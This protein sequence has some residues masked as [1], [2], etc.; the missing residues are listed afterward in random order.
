[1]QTHNSI[2]PDVKLYGYSELI[3]PGL[4]F[5]LNEVFPRFQTWN[6]INEEEQVTVGA[7]CMKIFHEFLMV[8]DLKEN[9]ENFYPNLFRKL[10]LHSVLYTPTGTALL[11]IV[12]TGTSLSF[13]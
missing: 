4:V 10:I 1:M 6:Y 2:Q 12:A 8:E 9:R 7:I 3:L 13:S 11:K 5:I